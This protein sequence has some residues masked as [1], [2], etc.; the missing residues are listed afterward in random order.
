LAFTGH[1][2]DSLEHGIQFE[3]TRPLNPSLLD[4][5]WQYGPVPRLLSLL[6]NKLSPRICIGC[7]KQ[8]I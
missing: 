6:V 2:T 3:A 7:R 8:L 5:A 4:L 1:T